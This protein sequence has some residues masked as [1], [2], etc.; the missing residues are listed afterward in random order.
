MVATIELEKYEKQFDMSTDDIF[1]N[2]F[3][4][5]NKVLRE[6]YLYDA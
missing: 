1:V 3:T 5:L 2:R 4:S 6:V